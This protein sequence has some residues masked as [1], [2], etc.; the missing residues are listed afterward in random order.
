M[1]KLMGTWEEPPPVEHHTYAQTLERLQG[2]APTTDPL[3]HRSSIPD[4]QEKAPT[5]SPHTLPDTNEEAPDINDLPRDRGERAQI[6]FGYVRE[7]ERG[8]RDRGYTGKTIIDQNEDGTMNI[9][10]RDAYGNIRSITKGVSG[11][12]AQLAT[13]DYD[14]NSSNVGDL[15]SWLHSMMSW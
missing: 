4:A 2:G 3:I 5:T 8:L 6:D 9:I 11:R 7:L 14:K 12:T 10:R 1:M 13:R 15:G